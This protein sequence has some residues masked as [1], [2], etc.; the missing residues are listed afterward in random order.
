MGLVPRGL[1]FCL[2]CRRP[3]GLV[4]TLKFEKFVARRL[5]RG[6]CLSSSIDG[7][8]Y[9]LPSRQWLLDLCR[10]RYVIFITM[11]SNIYIVQQVSLETCPWLTR[12][13]GWPT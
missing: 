6:C 4:F 13:V 8:S 5:L 10:T 12:M 7:T 1:V 11:C 9:P 2:K 3:F